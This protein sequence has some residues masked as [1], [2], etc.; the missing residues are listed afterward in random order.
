MVSMIIVGH[1]GGDRA[2]GTRK[3][4]GMQN[5]TKG[6]RSFPAKSILDFILKNKEKCLKRVTPMIEYF[7]VKY[8]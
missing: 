4:K 5:S 3:P 8:F 7:N 6:S 1:G 2:L